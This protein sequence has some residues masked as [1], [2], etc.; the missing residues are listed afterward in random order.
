VSCLLLQTVC[1]CLTHVRVCECSSYAG[2]DPWPR[3]KIG[4]QVEWDDFP[5][6]AIRSQGGVVSPKA[7]T[8]RVIGSR[9][10]LT[11]MASHDPR[12]AEPTPTVSKKIGFMLL[13]TLLRGSREAAAVRCCFKSQGVVAFVDHVAPPG[14]ARAAVCA[15]GVA[16][17][18]G[19]GSAP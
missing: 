10:I 8:G 3:W 1:P 4:D 16:K 9:Y 15:W 18:D 14:G 12:P 11:C 7:S 5:R 2:Q 13:L 6:D 17:R 19:G